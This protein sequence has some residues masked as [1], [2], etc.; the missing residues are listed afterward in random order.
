MGEST[1][2]SVAAQTVAKGDVLGT[3]RFAGAHAATETASLLALGSTVRVRSTTVEFT[4]ASDGI[5]IEVTVESD[6]ELGATSAA[7]SAATAAALTIYDMCK[8]ADRTM[9]IGPVRLAARSR[10]DEG[11]DDA[12]GG[13]TL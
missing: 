13:V 9:V 7:F 1:V 4:F 3:A 5:D 2:R 11:S 8:S 6:E 12:G 10:S